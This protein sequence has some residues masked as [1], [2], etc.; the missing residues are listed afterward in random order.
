MRRLH[1]GY[2]DARLLADG[3]LGPAGTR[4]RGHEFHYASVTDAGGDAA[5][6]SVVDAYGSASAP[7]GGR[8]GHVT[9]SFFHVMADAA[10]PV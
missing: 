7:A 1:L 8:R 4:L 10:G 2:R 6:A 3:C 5:F 9:G